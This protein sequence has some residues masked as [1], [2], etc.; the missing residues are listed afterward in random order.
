L[1]E[2]PTPVEK[3]EQLG[4]DIGI[5]HLFIKRDDLSGKV[6]GGNK[7]RKLEFLLSHALRTGNSKNFSDFSPIH[8]H[9][10]YVFLK[11]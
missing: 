7:I 9:N 1:G 5:N 10:L 2:F 4:K 3:L 8:K 6:Y 11:A